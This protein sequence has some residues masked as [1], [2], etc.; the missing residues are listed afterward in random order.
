MWSSWRSGAS[1]KFSIKNIHW[2]STLNYLANMT[3]PS[4]SPLAKQEEHAGHSC[5]CQN[6]LLGDTAMP[7]DGLYSSKAAHMERVESTFCGEYI[8]QVS[9]P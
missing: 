1:G 5:M 4:Q 6:V 8:V 2:Y 3:M 9:M 7:A